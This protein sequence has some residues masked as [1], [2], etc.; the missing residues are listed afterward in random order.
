MRLLVKWRFLF[1]S[2]VLYIIHCLLKQVIIDYI[3][4]LTRSR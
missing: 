3:L 4:Q 1:S 2:S